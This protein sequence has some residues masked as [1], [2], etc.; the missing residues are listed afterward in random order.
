MGRM[1]IMPGKAPDPKAMARLK[2]LNA[3]AVPAQDPPNDPRATPKK[4]GAWGPWRQ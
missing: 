4:G 1:A 3:T 2:E